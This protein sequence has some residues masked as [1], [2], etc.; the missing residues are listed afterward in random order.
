MRLAREQQ[1]IQ[2]HKSQQPLNP[3]TAHHPAS[4]PQP[5]N[6]TQSLAGTDFMSA[7]KSVF[8]QSTSGGASRTP[9]NSMNTSMGSSMGGM[10]TSMGSMSTSM[11][12]MNTSQNTMNTGVNWN[13]G[14]SNYS[15]TAVSSNYSAGTTFNSWGGQGQGQ[16][17]GQGQ[18]SQPSVQQKQSSDMSA[19]DSLLSMP[20]N[21]PTPSLNQMQQ[22]SQPPQWSPMGAGTNGAPNMGMGGNMNNQM[23]NSS[24]FGQFSQPQPAQKPTNDISDIFG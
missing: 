10:N 23:L 24:Q 15:S 2:R 19:F 4:K 20:S 17:Q 9:M 5:K 22:G 6:L 11:G 13:T 3:T 14:S 18:W 7:N 16:I 12:S 1:Q 21:K 8:N